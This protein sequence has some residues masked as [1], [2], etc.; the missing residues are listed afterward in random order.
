VLKDFYNL[1]GQTEMMLSEQVIYILLL[2]SNLLPAQ[3]YHGQ[4]LTH[5]FSIAAIDTFSGEMGV[6]VQSH[7][8]SGGSVVSWGRSG[9]GSFGQ[10]APF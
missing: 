8:F 4:P 10:S 3:L 6:A 7:W 1:R 5:T 2:S 9:A